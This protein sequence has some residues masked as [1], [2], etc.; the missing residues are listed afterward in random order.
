MMN[1][2]SMG[3]SSSEFSRLSQVDSQGE[4]SDVTPAELFVNALG[5]RHEGQLD[6][7]RSLAAEALEA[8]FEWFAST[9][10]SLGVATWVVIDGRRF[11]GLSQ[12]SL[13]ECQG[14]SCH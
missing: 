9:Q 14:E 8:E 1:A 10:E 6:Q 11:S 7:A 12:T 5:L 3:F 13:I 4:S 2:R